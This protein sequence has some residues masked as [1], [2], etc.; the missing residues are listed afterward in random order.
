VDAEIDEALQQPWKPCGW[1]PTVR[2]KSPRSV[3]LNAGQGF[4][5]KPLAPMLESRYP[6][7]FFWRQADS[8]QA[9]SHSEVEVG[10]VSIRGESI[11]V[12]CP[13]QVVVNQNVTIGP[14]SFSYTIVNDSDV[15]VLVSRVAAL[16]VSTQSDPLFT[17]EDQQRLIAPH[18]SFAQD[19]FSIFGNSA[20]GQPGQ[21]TA[22]GSLT[23]NVVSSGQVIFSDR[24]VCQF[25]VV[26]ASS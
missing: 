5:I 19:D 7:K 1:G 22:A 15:E 21:V 13:S 8:S 17:D 14:A 12:S 3:R 23:F 16:T 2:T 6:A 20:F 24:T 25:N 18:S 26:D 11:A 10:D 9:D 4:S